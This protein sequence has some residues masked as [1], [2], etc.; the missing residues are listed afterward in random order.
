[1]YLLTPVIASLA[2][3]PETK[4]MWFCAA[5]GATCSATPDESEP[6]MIL[7]PWPIRSL[8]AATAFAGSVAS[9]T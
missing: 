3:G 5:S 1:V 2:A 8:A 6:P 9:S 7:Y 4:R